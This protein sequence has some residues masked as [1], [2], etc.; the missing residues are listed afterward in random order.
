MEK[1]Q[2]RI[3]VLIGIFLLVFV[4]SI[5]YAAAAGIL[6]FNGTATFSKY[7]DV[8]FLNEGSGYKPSIVNE[9]VGE[10]IGVSG[11]TTLN[12]AVLLTEPT[13]TRTIKFKIQNNSNV[14]VT[15]DNLQKSDPTG[16]TITWPSLNGVVIPAK[17]STSEYSIIVEWDDTYPLSVGT[18]NIT[19]SV[20]YDETLAP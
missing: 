16:L 2:K 6:N 1:N 17:S 19:A 15:L 9:R 5:V 20:D 10:S 8:Y 11:K 4:V 14:S 7:F 3:G 12:F 13:D 18:V